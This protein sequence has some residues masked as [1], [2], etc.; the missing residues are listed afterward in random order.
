[1]KDI[2]DQSSAKRERIDPDI[3]DAL[4]D[5]MARTA[6]IDLKMAWGRKL[7]AKTFDESVEG[8]KF[9]NP[10]TGRQVLFKSLPSDEQAKI[11]SQWDS[12]SKGDSEHSDGAKAAARETAVRI[13]EGI[14]RPKGWRSSGDEPNLTKE[15]RQVWEAEHSAKTPGGSVLLGTTHMDVEDAT[16]GAMSHADPTAKA[17]FKEHVINGAVDAA[18]AAAK[19]GKK[20]VVLSEGT[21][22]GDDTL[23]DPNDWNEQHAVAK[24]VHEATGGKAV[25]DTWDDDTVSLTNPDSDV[26]KRLTS[27]AGGDPVK[28]KGALAV[29]MAGQGQS[30]D[31][32]VEDGWVDDDVAEAVTKATGTDPRGKLSKKT[33]QRFYDM[34]FPGDSGKPHTEVSA[35]GEVYNAARQENLLRKIRE[36]E[37]DGGVVIA[38]PGA[39]HAYNLKGAIEGRGKTSSDLSLEMAWGWNARVAAKISEIMS[40]IN[41]KVVS[42]AKSVTPKLKRAD[43]NNAMWT[44]TVP[45]SKG[46]TYTVKV[47]GLPRGNLRAVSK[48]DV[49]VSCSCPFFRYQGPEHWAKVGDYLYGK[50][51]G[52]ATRPDQ[53]D[54]DGRNRVCKHVAAVFERAGNMF[55]TPP[56]GKTAASEGRIFKSVGSVRTGAGNAQVVFD[57]EVTTEG[58]ARRA[59]Q[60]I[61]SIPTRDLSMSAARRFEIFD[62][63]EDVS[64]RLDEVGIVADDLSNGA[65]DFRTGIVYACVWDGYASSFRTLMHEI[66]HSIVGRDEAMAESWYANR[67]HMDAKWAG[68]DRA[69]NMFYTPPKGKT[70]ASTPVPDRFAPNEAGVMTRDEYIRH[71]NPDD[72]FHPST[73]YNYSTFDLNERYAR[74]HLGTVRRTYRPTLKVEGST[75]GTLFI[76]EDDRPVAVLHGGTLYHDDRGEGIPDEYHPAG[77][78]EPVPLDIRDRRR[79]KYIAEYV[80]KV[81]DLARRTATRYPVVLRR[82]VHGGEPMTLR[83]E[84][85]PVPDKGVNLVVADS[86]GR[87]LGV[88]QNEWGA[89]LIAVARDARGRGIGAILSKVW[90]EL[91]P[92]FGS[93]GMTGA[94]NALMQ[95]VWADRVREFLSLGWYTQMVR[96]G[97]MTPERVRE[98]LAD[99][100]GRRPRPAAPQPAAPRPAAP[101]PMVMSDGETFVTVYDR[102]VLDDPGA[103]ASDPDDDMVYGHAFLRDAPG[104]GTFVYSIEYD[105][106]FAELTTRAILQLARD[107]G[108]RLYVGDRGYHDPLEGVESIPGV[109]VDGDY[110]TV[111]SDVLPLRS[112]A[113][114]ERRTRRPV[115]PH[116]EVEVALME[117][118]D[119]KWR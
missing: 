76:D 64:Q 117:R 31:S 59:L 40:G 48:M 29:F 14:D 77:R 17:S 104:V 83:A 87:I 58:T 56:K 119:A 39:S 1:M 16:T 41:P 67:Q 90:H 12:R 66:G 13:V 38:A 80:A 45:G 28:A 25:Q 37:A 15:N 42:G 53:K 94:G 105:R 35:I 75:S 27:A 113:E 22:Y 107:N 50:P 95:S 49:E 110:L 11:R 47:K 24:A 112:M 82:F 2:F 70:A 46:E 100:P 97:R 33:Q 91:N 116:G 111:G 98:I 84:K 65:F 68:F 115:D 99:L 23:D 74:R 93:G 19:A 109:T 69:G 78:G 21:T 60:F 4:S 7:V 8:K 20:V 62:N 30:W 79:V 86:A 18:K 32:M 108:Y 52:T 63:P 72:R 101:R 96:D 6:S 51:A 3:L 55:Y 57:P 89:T 36:V 106:R 118:A 71:L 92:S 26:W 5:D 54:P 43:P 34:A 88:A 10:E 9:K 81:D 44:Y 114:L 85:Q 102:A 73:A 61:K 103:F